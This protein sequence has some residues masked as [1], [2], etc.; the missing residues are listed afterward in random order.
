MIERTPPPVPRDEQAG[1]AELFGLL[2]ACAE[3]VVNSSDAKAFL[4]WIAEAGPA[5]APR[6]AA[7]IDP[8]TGP[9]GLVFRAIGVSIYNAMPLPGAGFRPRPI[10]TPGRNEPC[11]CGSGHKYKHCCLPLAGILDL[12][13]YNMLRHVL[14][15]L[16][17]KVF[18]ALPESAVDVIAV[19]DAAHQWHDEGDAERA[20]AL[21]E[22][23]F[24][25][26]R[27]LKAKLEPLF[28]QLMDSYLAIGQERKRER[29]L[30]EVIARG[31]RGLR[32]AAMQ[33]R[34]TM[35]ADRGRTE[36][37][38]AAFREAQREDPDN[39]SLAALEVTLLVSHG[40]TEQA[41]ERARFWIARLERSRDPELADLI[42][43]LR[44]VAADPAAAMAQV[45]RDMNPDLD[46]LAR[47]LGAAPAIEPRYTIERSEIEGALKADKGLATIE[48]RW[49]SIF[50]QTKP[51]LTATQHGFTGM[52]DNAQPWLDFLE[53]NALAWQSFDVL[54]DLA[55]AVDALPS[56]G[57]DAAG[58]EPLI[59]RGVALL[60]ANLNAAGKVSVGLPWGCL[61]NRPA[62]RMLAHLAFRAQYAT[63]P[64]AGNS[65]F[66]EL[67]EWLIA[68]NPND[69]HGLR[70]H[71]AGAYLA[72][73]EPGKALALAE[74]YPDD[75]CGMTLNRI[76]A[77]Y[78]L[79]RR[80]D[81]LQTLHTA[82]RDHAVAIKMLLAVDP[83]EPRASG[84][85]ITV[86]G[87]DEA[88]EYRTAHR[89]L[90]ERDGALEWL[91]DVWRAIRK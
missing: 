20:A 37:A 17:K 90:W 56:L 81:A 18:L 7:A 12:R 33:R 71:L 88:W 34:A 54:D 41:R 64:A 55:M 32:S 53:Q 63:D 35:L 59:E 62:L 86:G 75:F 65:R 50:P 6:F 84:Y 89:A 13:D 28:D 47:L 29:L 77:L 26:D 23:W 19:Y 9:P 61:E 16:P 79:G 24:A 51:S 85:G 91:R 48:E 3:T 49:R 21:L 39:P 72:R 15:A 60:K 42:A 68:L 4:D 45:S 22:P 31:D 1:E 30:R 80:G 2:A 44:Q 40:E 36:D 78:R 70:E 66:V 57:T 67:A 58:L 5:H 14:D 8:R 27:E 83:K 43:F 38:W 10:P 87:K 11:S 52:W 74:R 25:A 76:L 46:R 82:A 69:N 73:A